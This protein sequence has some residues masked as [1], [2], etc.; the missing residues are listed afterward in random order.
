MQLA[1]HVQEGVW[2]ELRGECVGEKHVFLAGEV[3]CACVHVQGITCAH[4]TGHV[5]G[6]AWSL[7]RMRTSSCVWRC[8][9]GVGMSK[10]RPGGCRHVCARLGQEGRTLCSCGAGATCAWGVVHMR[11]RVPW[12]CIEGG[13][14]R[15]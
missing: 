7:S 8:W 11:V 10:H 1:S 13:Q 12:L 14:A 9:E 6:C 4:N 2:G 15:I 3:A 5:W